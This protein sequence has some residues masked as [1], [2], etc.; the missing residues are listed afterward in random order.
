M[1]YLYATTSCHIS[2]LR[3]QCAHIIVVLSSS[4]AVCHSQYLYV[5]ILLFECNYIHSSEE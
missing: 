5:I 2:H 1:M 3:R 4:S